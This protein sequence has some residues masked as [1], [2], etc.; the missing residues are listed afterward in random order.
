[1]NEYYIKWENVLNA[2]VLKQNQKLMW[3]RAKLLNELNKLIFNLVIDELK[4]IIRPIIST[5]IKEK[6]TQYIRLLKS[7]VR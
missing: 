2:S 6:I 7:L 4:N 5:I 1:M 3:R